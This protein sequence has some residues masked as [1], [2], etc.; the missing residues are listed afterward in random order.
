[1]GFVVPRT[2]ACLLLLRALL[3]GKEGEEMEGE[4]VEGW[5]EKRNTDPTFY[6]LPAPLSP[7]N[8]DFIYDVNF[9]YK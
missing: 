3:E 1:M 6:D 8:D 4:G 2:T 9:R 7:C 5:G